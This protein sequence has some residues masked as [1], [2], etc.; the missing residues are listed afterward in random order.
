MHTS[1][2]ATITIFDRLRARYSSSTWCSWARCSC[3]RPRWRS[4]KFRALIFITSHPSWC[5]FVYFTRHSEDLGEF[6]VSKI[7]LTTSWCILVDSLIAFR[8]VVWTD[9][10]QFSAMVLAVVIVMFLGTSDVG[11]VQ[12]VFT[13]AQEGNRL[14]WF[15]WV[16]FNFVESF[17]ALPDSL[18]MSRILESPP[19]HGLRSF[20][21]KHILDGYDRINNALGLECRHYARMCPTFRRH[22]KAQWCRQG[23]LD[24]WRRT[25]HHQ[26]VRCL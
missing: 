25:H 20:P 9:T 19:Q 22:S 12:K 15:E 24:F 13:I 4:V 11:G 1:R 14:I 7:Y 16:K 17:S 3:I 5:S 23:L 18:L 8:A 21:K 10:L 2:S 6:V 26:A